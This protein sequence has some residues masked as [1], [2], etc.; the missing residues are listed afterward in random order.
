M[1]LA[2]GTFFS[3]QGNYTNFLEA[4]AARQGI[5]DDQEK[6]RQKFL[7]RELEWVR[8]GPRARRTKSRDRIDRYHETAAQDGPEQELDVD[9]IIPP[10]PKLANRVIELR[11]VGMTLGGK[12]LFKDFSLQMA[13]GQR[14]GHRRAQRAGQ[15]DAAQD[16]ARRDA[17]HQ[18]RGRD[19]FAHA[20]QLRRPGTV[21][22]Q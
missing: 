4:K 13:E 22:A 15:D 10:A 5:N 8:R 12:T 18:R 21:A 11:E 17:A 16:H 9:L 14:L 1:E 6:R 2:E 3:H 20:D 7:K 19:R